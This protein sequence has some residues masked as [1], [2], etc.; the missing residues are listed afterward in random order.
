MDTS[1]RKALCASVL[2]VLALTAPA[3]AQDGIRQY[4]AAI[5]RIFLWKYSAFPIFRQ[6]PIFPGSVVRVDN[7]TIYL[8]PER[9]YSHKQ[10]GNYRRIADYDEGMAIATTA[11]LRIKGEVLSKHVAE[12]EAKAG[13]KFAA[14]TLI[15]VSPLS[16]DAFQPDTAALEKIKPDEDCKL[17]LRLLSGET[18]GYIVAANVLHGQV[19]YLLKTRMESN[20]SVSARSEMLA[21]IAKAFAIKEAEIAVSHGEA[22][23]SVASSPAPLTLA[24]VPVSL[25]LEELSRII[26]YL[27][28]ERG[29]QLESAVDQ[30]LTAGNAGMFSEARNLVMSILSDEIK[31]KELWASNFVNGRKRIKTGYLKPDDLRKIANYA[32]AMEIIG[33]D[34]KLAELPASSAP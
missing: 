27:Q 2:A 33:P 21:R 28:G 8:S 24:I 11:D 6:N 5:T 13:V 25:N 34:I 1:W 4:R 20:A 3:A 23:F 29:A 32:A 10:G 14:S 7:E 26:Y 18:G 22:A 31:N 12:A 9:C 17:I 16:L 15:T 30:A 19:R